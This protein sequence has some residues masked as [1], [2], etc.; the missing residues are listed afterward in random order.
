MSSAAATTLLFALSWCLL[1]TLTNGVVS[2]LWPGAL[3]AGAKALFSLALCP[4]LF[5]LLGDYAIFGPTGR[6]TAQTDAATVVGSDTW[7][8]KRA[9]GVARRQNTGGSDVVWARLAPDAD[10]AAHEAT[11][12]RAIGLC[13]QGVA[14]RHDVSDEPVKPLLPAWMWRWAVPDRVDTFR[15]ERAVQYGARKERTG[16]Y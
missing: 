7:L 16:A 10:W 3:T 6:P 1:F 9:G 11:T 13:K 15:A 8:D 2:S 5:V 12:G 14:V 4:G